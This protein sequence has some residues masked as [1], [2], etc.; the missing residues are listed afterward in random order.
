MGQFGLISLMIGTFL[1]MDVRRCCG[2]FCSGFL[3]FR[4]L[5]GVSVGSG[6]LSPSING[7]GA[8]SLWI[9]PLKWPLVFIFTLIFAMIHVFNVFI[10]YLFMIYLFSNAIL[11]LLIIEQVFSSSCIVSP[12]FTLRLAHCHTSSTLI[13]Y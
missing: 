2:L 1:I 3:G 6:F 5:F 7:A 11:L 8:G 10:I 9:S 13:W 4:S 12:L